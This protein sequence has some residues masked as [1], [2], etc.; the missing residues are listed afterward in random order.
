M[1]HLVFWP[2]AHTTAA[3]AEGQQ[4]QDRYRERQKH[5]T[6]SLEHAHAQAAEQLR[7]LRLEN[8]RLR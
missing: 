7:A 4:A 5:A 6:A 1:H 3:R 8:D 2:F